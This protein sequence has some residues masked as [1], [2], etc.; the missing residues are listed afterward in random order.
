MGLLENNKSIGGF[1]KMKKRI[2][3]KGL[4]DVDK[5]DME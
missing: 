3:V 5:S 4:I 2:E 1:I